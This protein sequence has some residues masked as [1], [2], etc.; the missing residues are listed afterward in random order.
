MLAWLAGRESLAWTALWFLVLGT[1]SAA[2]AAGTGL[3]ARE[4][5][6]VDPTVREQ[7]LD[8]HKSWMLTT[9]GLSAALTV[10]ALGGAAF[11]GAGPEP[12]R[13]ASPRRPGG[14]GPWR[15]LRGPARVRLQCRG[16]R[17]RA[18]DRVHTVMRAR[19]RGASTGAARGRHG[20]AD[21]VP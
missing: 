3:H 18:A 19:G 11:P 12:L 21:G 8:P 6:M 2:V 17:V 14:H 20:R 4:G 10:W 5:V 13:P 9:L 1:A 15:R 7:L 16:E